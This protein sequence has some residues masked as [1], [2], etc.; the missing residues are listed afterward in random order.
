MNHQIVCETLNDL[1]QVNN[2]RSAAYSDAIENL[3]PGYDN[4][5]ALFS[6][7]IEESKLYNAQLIAELNKLDE[8]VAEGTSGAGKLYRAWMDVKALFTGGGA[9]PI[10]ETCESIEHATQ[11]AY[12]DA[13][14]EEGNSEEIVNLISE[15]K[16]LL[17]ESHNQ[18]KQLLAIAEK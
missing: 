3:Q 6:K 11:T 15:Q 18:I 2:D 12:D 7:M 8:A 13:L 5:K 4:L 9:K 14:H 16:L 17:V 1:V 10:L